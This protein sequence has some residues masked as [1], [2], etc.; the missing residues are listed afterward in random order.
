MKSAND[1]CA[2]SDF[3]DINALTLLRFGRKLQLVGYW[4]TN[5]GRR[6]RYYRVYNGALYEG[7]TTAEIGDIWKANES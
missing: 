3:L 5:N 7:W 2:K 4:S 1:K 6:E